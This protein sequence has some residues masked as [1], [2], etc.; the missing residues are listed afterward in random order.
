MN[1]S[2][3]GR[4]F[5]RLTYV[6]ACHWIIKESWYSRSWSTPWNVTT[7]IESTVRSIW[8]RMSSYLT[9]IIASTWTLYSRRLRSWRSCI[10]RSY[11]SIRRRS[12]GQRR[13]STAQWAGET[14]GLSPKTLSLSTGCRDISVWRLR[15]TKARCRT[16]LTLLRV[17]AHLMILS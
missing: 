11:R 3:T 7:V 2:K 10:G 9:K 12:S 5:K 13:T 6:G 4:S 14:Q 8:T 17:R 1:W 15:L 16:M